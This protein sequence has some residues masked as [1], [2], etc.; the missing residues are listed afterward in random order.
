MAVMDGLE[1]T[2][3]IRAL[4][5][6]RE[7]RIVAISASVFKEER[8]NVMRAGLDDFIRKPYR[9]NEIFDCLTRN[10][11]VR[12]ICEEE[13]DGAQASS[14]LKAC[15]GAIAAL[16]DELRTALADALVGLDTERIT[17]LIRQITER[18]SALG[19]ALAYQSDQF[20]FTPM[21]H[22]LRKL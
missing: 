11:G 22:A 10:L 16:P 3:R 12:F 15:A 7:V 1:A 9:T 17:E 8:E 18:D 19:Q 21:L 5:G 20:A 6:G 4:E 13:T 14:S 2:Q